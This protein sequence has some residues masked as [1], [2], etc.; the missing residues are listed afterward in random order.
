M[1]VY[2]KIRMFILRYFCYL[3]ISC[4]VSYFAIASERV[5]TIGIVVGKADVVNRNIELKIKENIFFGDV[6]RT[7]AQTNL[8]ILFDDETVFTIGENTEIVINEFI[9]DPN[10]DNACLLYTSPSPRDRTRSRM[11]SSA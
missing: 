6:I 1:K 8:Q 9:Y 3:L 7:A 2:V 10:Q 11:P 5:G 4:S